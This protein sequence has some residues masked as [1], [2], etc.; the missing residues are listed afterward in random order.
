MVKR[1]N[2]KNMYCDPRGLEIKKKTRARM[3][4]DKLKQYG[5]IERTQLIS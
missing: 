1:E 5:E 3:F 2:P 4:D